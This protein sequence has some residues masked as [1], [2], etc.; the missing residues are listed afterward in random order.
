MAKTY[1][2]AQPVA[3]ET[4]IN[5]A[6]V[7]KNF[8][9]ML[10][11]EARVRE[12]K[13]DAIN[14]AT[15]QFQ[16]TLNDV[17]QGQSATA[18]QWW[19]QAASDIQEQMLMQE[20]LLKSGALK[21]KEYT[22]MRQN[23]TDGTDGLIN[24]FNKYNKEFSERMERTKD[25]DNQYLEE[26]TMA[27]L[28]NFGN[29]QETA[30]VTNPETG[31][32]SVAMVDDNGQIIN[33]P[34]KIRSITSLQSLIAQR[35]D[36]YDLEGSTTA[37]ADS[38][39]VWEDIER[40][41]GSRAAKGMMTVVSDPMDKTLGLSELQRLGLT[42]EE[43]IV[44][45]AELGIYAAD[46]QNFVDNIMSVW[47]NTSSILTNTKRTAPNGEVY[48]FTFS[49]DRKEN[50]I[51][52]KKDGQGIIY[53]EYTPE[54]KK[55]VSK[56]IK[57]SIRNKLNR[58]IKQPSV[59]SD[60][61]APTRAESQASGEQKTNEDYVTNITQLYSGTQQQF[62]TAADFIRSISG[63]NIVDLTRDN[64]GVTVI[65]SNGNSE[66]LD[67]SGKNESN[68]VISNANKLLSSPISDVKGTLD[69]SGALTG[70]ATAT[71]AFERDEEG[72]PI[73]DQPISYTSKVDRLITEDIGDTIQRALTEDIT[74]SVNSK[75]I[76]VTND[77][78]ASISRVEAVI[79]SIPT[80]SEWLTVDD[81]ED[82][83]IYTDGLMVK[84][85]ETGSV[86]AGPYYFD[87]DA[88]AD[89]KKKNEQDLINKL[90]SYYRSKVA[91]EDQEKEFK[92][93]QQQTR[94]GKSVTQQGELN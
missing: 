3:A 15:R 94:G 30:V 90:V 60:Y 78:D 75:E 83:N 66:T 48:D 69:A 47:S 76:F 57:N 74:A 34:N 72:Q 25:E 68:W 85:K 37:W 73:V 18:N 52:L 65:Y 45:Q 17:E 5:W 88:T 31:M 61:V 29:F 14:E 39:G 55:E 36:R 86:V 92:G 40:K 20:R 11:E 91:N 32:M 7:G 46:E 43:A 6:E 80:I 64:S 28:E 2:K 53:A 22:M 71:K 84:D 4:Q 89:Q 62:E 24:V 42:R 59:V 77:E 8:T 63:G 93:R 49:E 51:L 81:D 13:K 41:Y 50:E 27:E 33:D 9:D 12:E 67:F 16:N 58:K 56:A 19:L 54:Q 10:S 44:A 21:P 38:V 35:Y 26:W 87:S 1:F 23:L 82:I 70:A 79:N